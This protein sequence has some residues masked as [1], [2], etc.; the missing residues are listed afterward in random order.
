LLRGDFPA[1]ESFFLRALE[2]DA[3]YNVTARQ[4][5]SYL[6]NLKEVQKSE[7]GGDKKAKN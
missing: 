1:A 5:L 6:Q 7:S 3:A 2:T 4:N